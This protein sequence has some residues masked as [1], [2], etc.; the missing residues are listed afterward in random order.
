MA[1]KPLVGL[2]GFRVISSFNF[3]QFTCAKLETP[4]FQ[5][6]IVLYPPEL[7]N[8][9]F[10]ISARNCMLKLSDEHPV[11]KWLKLQSAQAK[12]DPKLQEKIDFLSEILNSP[13]NLITDQKVKNKVILVLT[14]VPEKTNLEKLLKSYLY[15]MI[16]NLTRS[17]RIL[18]SIINQPPRDF[19]K[20]YSVKAGVYHR[21]M[22]SHV[23]K[24]LRKFSRHPADRLTFFLFTSYLKNFANKPDLLDLVDDLDLGELTEKLRLSYTERIQPSLVGHIRLAR[25]S[26][27]RRIKNLRSPAYTPQMQSLWVWPFLE[28][29]PLVS[30]GMVA[31]VKRLDQVDPLWAI[32]LLDDEKLADLY[33]SKGG[34]SIARRRTY[35]RVHLSDPEDFMLTLFKLIE[36]GDI[37]EDLVSSVSNFL[38]DE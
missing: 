12:P 11:K 36:I 2:D 19:Y 21:L 9:K 28:V 34:V 25:M 8:E 35:L 14:D 22:A 13:F 6:G 38:K 5:L 17:D 33:V 32:Y 27:K 30:E 29:G 37:N 10:L 23:E 20:G 18:K 7:I 16:G 24:V 15:L 31:E 3:E 4:I 1:F 26:E